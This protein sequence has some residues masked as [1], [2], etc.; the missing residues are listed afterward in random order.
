MV[1]LDTYLFIDLDDRQRCHGLENLVQC[2][3]VLGAE[4]HDDHK[5]HAAIGG[6]L[7]EEYFQR[8][9]A[10]GR[11][12]DAHHRETQVRMCRR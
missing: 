8:L 4:V 12:T 7:F 6:H 5:R 11:G 2:A 1:A 3:L 10:T 9:Q